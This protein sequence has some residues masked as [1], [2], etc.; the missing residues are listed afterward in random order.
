MTS[1]P[2]LTRKTYYVTVISKER[3]RGAIH[4]DRE[5]AGMR[6]APAWQRDAIGAYYAAKLLA[7]PER[8]HLCKRC[9]GMK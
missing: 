4:E 1:K 9:K 3:N 8:W 6:A 5:C 2:R 7:N